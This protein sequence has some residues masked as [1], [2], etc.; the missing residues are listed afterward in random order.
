MRCNHAEK[1]AIPFTCW[2]RCTFCSTSARSL[3]ARIKPPM[4]I[5][6]TR[7]R[8][9]TT[10]RQAVEFMVFEGLETKAAAEK[11]GMKHHSLREALKK[12][13]VKELRRALRDAHL[14]A[15]GERAY[16]IM[17][18][19]M[20]NS[21]SDH[22]KLEAASKVADFAGLTPAET[23]QH[24]HRHEGEVRAG[25]V[26]VL[27]DQKGDDQKTIDDASGTSNGNPVV[28]DGSAKR[29]Q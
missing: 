11:A 2:C 7:H 17:C 5:K 21:T 15:K 6:L 18:D 9:S 25:Y 14:R 12:P 24:L 23:V 19:L 29:I 27:R 10:T 22:V 1:S 13:H 28:I 20:E 26:I 8:I 4:S 16:A 3:R